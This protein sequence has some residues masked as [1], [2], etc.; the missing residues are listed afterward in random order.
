MTYRVPA[1]RLAELY[2]LRYLKKM[3]RVA[4]FFRILAAASI[5]YEAAAIWTNRGTWWSLFAGVIMI[6][7]GYLY[8][9]WLGHWKRYATAVKIKEADPGAQR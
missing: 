7:W 6:L 4:T 3:R 8:F 1:D 5:G 2:S 9:S